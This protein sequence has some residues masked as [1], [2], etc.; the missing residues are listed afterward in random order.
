[1]VGM[2]PFRKVSRCLR[3]AWIGV[4]VFAAGFFPAPADASVHVLVDQVGYELQATKQA[5]VISAE[6]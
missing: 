3:Q 4:V 1:M 5:L 2:I 6:R